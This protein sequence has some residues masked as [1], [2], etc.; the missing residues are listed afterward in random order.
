[1]TYFYLYLLPFKAS[2]ACLMPRLVCSG[3]VSFH[4]EVFVF[5]Y[6]SKV[7]IL[8]KYYECLIYIV[9]L[10]SELG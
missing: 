1:M 9:L 7:K 5:D 2:S 10:E 6:I 3:L 4:L 8:V